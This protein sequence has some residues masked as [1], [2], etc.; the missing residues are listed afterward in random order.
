MDTIMTYLNNMFATLPKTSDMNRLKEDLLANMEDK[1]EELKQNGKS[2]N[3]AI[4][5]VI[6]EFGNIDELVSELNIDVKDSIDKEH[7]YL[8][9]EQVEDY[10]D[11]TKKAGKL[12]G[13]GVGICQIGVVFLLLLLQLGNAGGMIG[14]AALFLFV[15]AAVGL[16][17]YAGTLMEKHKYLSNGFT[18][19]DDIKIS[20]EHEYELFQ[21]TFTKAIV[22]GVVLCILSPVVLIVLTSINENSVIYGVI[23]LL[24]MVA[25]AVYLFVSTGNQQAAYRTLL[26]KGDQPNISLPHEKKE[27][28]AIR[29]ASVILWPLTVCIFLISGFLY[30]QWHINWIIFPI[31][32]LLFAMFSG[33]Y[34]II[35]EKA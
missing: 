2:E 10:L 27:D 23:F 5:I 28:K 31:V 18:L 15:A 9:D 13:F 30:N 16:F 34:S 12:I 4:G 6:S 20:L 35:K 24:L 21:P 3:E 32:G 11:E 33:A 22:T 25:L 17:I 14:I 8:T 1:Y 7:P 19:P 29:V 26:K